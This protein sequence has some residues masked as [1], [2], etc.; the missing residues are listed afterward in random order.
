[1]SNLAVSAQVELTIDFN[2]EVD[3]NSDINIKDQACEYI[4]SCILRGRIG[5]LRV[6]EIKPNPTPKDK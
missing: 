5:G 4:N 1:M 6:T 3:L 2:F